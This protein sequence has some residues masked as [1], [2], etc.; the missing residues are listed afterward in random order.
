MPPTSNPTP[1]AGGS[2]AGLPPP[3]SGW[4][5][6]ASTGG[7]P[8]GGRKSPIRLLITF[9]ATLGIV[10]LVVG[11]AVAVLTPPP[12]P[13]DCP[14]PSQPCGLPP[15]PP[16]L[17]PATVAPS[18]GI[19]APP[20][21]PAPDPNAQATT[22]PTPAVTPAP[23]VTPSPVPSAAATPVA[24]PSAVP[25]ATK[26]GLLNLP[27]PQPASNAAPQEFGTVWTSSELGFRFQY[28]SGI[29]TIRDQ[30]ARSV[31]LTA[32]RG[33][34]AVIIAGSPA[35]DTTPDQAASNELDRLNS[36]ILGFTDETDPKQLLPGQPV[37]GYQP[38]IGGLFAGTLDNPQGPS[39]AVHSAVLA[40]TDSRLTILVS[41]T[42]IDQ[43]E[44]PAFQAVDSMLN[45][46]DWG[47]A[48]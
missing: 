46:L 13:P 26:T 35:Q 29:W 8:G 24:V 3:V 7:R 2:S 1:P 16:T 5:G 41:V 42:T 39:T 18:T 40:A 38:G 31:V 48:P 30:D 34:V 36:Q 43:L 17:P 25:S 21:L 22:A 47:T 12:A 6:P 11:A 45:T 9:V 27:S 44:K 28:D 33:N 32:A 19:T 14:D 20:S 4:A 37:V 23:V 10:L 15:A